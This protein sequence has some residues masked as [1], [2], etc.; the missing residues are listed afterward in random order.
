M[1]ARER[2]SEQGEPFTGSF[3]IENRSPERFL[4]AD[5]GPAGGLWR[6]GRYAGGQEPHACTAVPRYLE[7]GQVINA[8]YRL[9]PYSYEEQERR[10]VLPSG[11]YWLT[12]GIA[13][14]RG[15][16]QHVFWAAEAVTVRID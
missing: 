2:Q 14:S 11:F 9:L 12:T 13:V 3:R 1:T 7:P 10:T 5:C 4:L 6:D 8:D 16:N 15:P